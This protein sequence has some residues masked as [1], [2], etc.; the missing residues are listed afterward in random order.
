MKLYL[1]QHGRATSKED[2]PRRPLTDAGR[3]ELERMA[4][5]VRPLGLAV[6]AA[7]DSGKER[8]SQSAAILAGAFNVRGEQTS[9]SGL[10]AKDDVTAF[11]DELA[12]AG[13]DVLVVGHQP[14]LGKLAAYLL[15]DSDATEPVAFRNGG[16]VHL[17]D[18]RQA[19][20][21]LE[22][23]VTPDLLS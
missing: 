15:T 5:L 7:W 22:W 13:R 6:D 12:A 20:W 14:F 11:G 1:V 9:R 17:S 18:D 10:G 23:A 19:K 3:A 21:Q 8:A 2:N 16:I 4:D